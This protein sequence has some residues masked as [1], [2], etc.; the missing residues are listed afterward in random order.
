LLDVLTQKKQKLEAD[1]QAVQH[2]L[3]KD[4]LSQVKRHKQEVWY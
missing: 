2:E 1:S 4:F 3:L